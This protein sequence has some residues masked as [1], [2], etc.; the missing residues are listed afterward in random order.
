MIINM[1]RNLCGYIVIYHGEMSFKPACKVVCPRRSEARMSEWSG[2]E[3]KV[4]I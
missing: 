3:V 1:M 2:D 4:P